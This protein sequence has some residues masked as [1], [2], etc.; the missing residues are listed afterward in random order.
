MGLDEVGAA[1]ERAAFTWPENRQLYP[2]SQ[3]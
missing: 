2:A 3:N 1:G